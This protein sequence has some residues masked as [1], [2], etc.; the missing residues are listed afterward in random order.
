[1]DCP[2][3]CSGGVCLAAPITTTSTTS[4]STT[5]PTTL[6]STTTTIQI[7]VPTPTVRYFE[8]HPI[9]VD[10]G[11]TPAYAPKKVELTDEIVFAITVAAVLLTLF[12]L[13]KISD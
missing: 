13:Y 8:P 11:I 3:G 1:M 6:S 4:T 5:P 10:H 7:I 9:V 2:A 12:I